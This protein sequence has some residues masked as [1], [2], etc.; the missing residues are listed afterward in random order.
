MK[1]ADIAT[2]APAWVYVLLVVLIVLGVRRL[3]T[4][5]AP[6]AVALI[7]VIAFLAWSIVGAN[8]YAKIVGSTI[9][10]A[11]WLGGAAVGVVSGIVL[12]DPRGQ[13]LP[14]GRLRQPGTTIPLI[15]YLTVFVARFACGAWAAIVPAQA[16]TALGVGVAVGAAMTA[17]LVVGAARWQAPVSA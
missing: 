13:R 5:D 7:P 8:S 10:L 17:R 9:A 14:G 16:A 15:L 12:P 11:C 3:R 2:G 1:P 6:L 4:R